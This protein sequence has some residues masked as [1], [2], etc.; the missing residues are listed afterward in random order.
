VFERVREEG[1]YDVSVQQHRVVGLSGD[2]L[3]NLMR[4]ITQ[5]AKVVDNRIEAE[6]GHLLSTIQAIPI[7]EILEL[8][9]DLRIEAEPSDQGA[10]RVGGTVGRAVR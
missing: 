7:E 1:V 3:H 9:S 4:L 8:A 2:D 6:R 5:I 10:E